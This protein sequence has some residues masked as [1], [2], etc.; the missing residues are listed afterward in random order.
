MGVHLLI[1]VP[2]F[3]LILSMAD[4]CLRKVD[5]MEM[6]FAFQSAAV[7]SMGW[8]SLSSLLCRKRQRAAKNSSVARHTLIGA[9]SPAGCSW[10]TAFTRVPEALVIVRCRMSLGTSDSPLRWLPSCW[11]LPV[12]LVLAFDDR[13]LRVVY[14]VPVYYG[15]WI[16]PFHPPTFPPEQRIH[17][18]QVYIKT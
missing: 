15:S 11:C 6:A 16:G 7:W 1:D 8:G 9:I 4:S 17:N 10:G 3:R 5:R 12:W 14:R 18:I 2:T 13:W